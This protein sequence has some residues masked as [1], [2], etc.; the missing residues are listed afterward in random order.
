VGADY[1]ERRLA[2]GVRLSAPTAAP[3]SDP[4]ITANPSGTPK[5]NANPSDSAALTSL[6]P[7]ATVIGT[8]T[9]A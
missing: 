1:G 2:N 6:G 5:A 3:I 8:S 9:A 7:V 4:T